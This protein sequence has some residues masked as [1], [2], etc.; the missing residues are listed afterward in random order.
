MESR[1]TDVT[2]YARGARIR[3]TAALP[4][5]EPARIRIG[6]LPAAVIDD[7]VRI[8]AAGGPI[9]TAVR[10]GLDAPSAE[11]AADED[12]PEVRAARRRVALAEA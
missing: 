7:T 3:R 2:L 1:I 8:E 10:V 4:A 12:T 11:A 9:V 5:G 6:G